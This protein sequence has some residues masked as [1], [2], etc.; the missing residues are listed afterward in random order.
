MGMFKDDGGHF[1]A[2]SPPVSPFHHPGIVPV[3][4]VVGLTYMVSDRRITKNK[5]VAQIVDIY[6]TV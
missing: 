3:N 5:V 1:D 6:I 4:E 2:P